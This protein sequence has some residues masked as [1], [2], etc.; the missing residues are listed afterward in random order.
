MQ[1]RPN[2]LARFNGAADGMMT[3]LVILLFGPSLFGPAF[4]GD[5][6]GDGPRTGSVKVSTETNADLV[7][8]SREG[9]TLT[10]SFFF[11]AK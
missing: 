7:T 1:R 6:S 8:A 11:S 9:E 10:A 2:E 3:I 5:P 4:R